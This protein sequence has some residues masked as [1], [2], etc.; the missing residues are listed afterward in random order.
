MHVHAADEREYY[1]IGDDPPQN[2]RQGLRAR[3]PDCQ[4]AA[5]HRAP[6]V[7]RQGENT[8]QRMNAGTN[9]RLS[10]NERQPSTTEL[11]R[12]EPGQAT[13]QRPEDEQDKTT[14]DNEQSP[15]AK[16]PRGATAG[17]C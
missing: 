14:S 13:S 4:H 10:D 8:N 3:R 16:S 1:D 11:L 15:R 6:R 2:P 9:K 5:R 7:K 12:V 17:R